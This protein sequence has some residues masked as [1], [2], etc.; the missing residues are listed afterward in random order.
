MGTDLKEVYWVHDHILSPLG[1]STQ[2][3]LDN[4]VQGHVGFNKY[5]APA[6]YNQET[7]ISFINCE[8]QNIRIHS[9]F[10]RLENLMIDSIQNLLNTNQIPLDE[11]TQLFISS[12]KGNID[13]I[14]NPLIQNQFEKTRYKLSQLGKTL[15]L[16]FGFAK[17]P[18]I[19]S[20][21]CVSGSLALSVA[22]DY[23]K[24][25]PIENA[26]IC[27]GDEISEF[28]YA[29]FNSFQ[30]LSSQ[31]CKPFDQ[32]RTGLNLGEAIVS[33]HLSNN[34]KS[35][36]PIGKMKGFG[37]VNDANHISGPSR[38][39]EGLFKSI[40]KAL[41]NSG[42]DKNQL[43]CISSHGTSTLYNDEM[44]SIALKRAGLSEVPL[45]SLKGYY[46]H[47]LGASALLETVLT[48]HSL[49]KNIILG[50]KGF[51]TEGTSS[52]VNI[53]QHH[54]ETQANY[55]LKLSSGFGGCNVAQITEIY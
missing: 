28:I 48:L 6:W 40:E 5:S 3:N 30:A 36:E 51:E 22:S 26:L 25:T 1:K 18:L 7:P 42:I 35:Y 10:T 13:L 52:S 34:S 50:T 43:G 55:F 38:T 32:N 14:H 23:L 47:T 46:G 27:G 21:A 20:N 19:I 12:T 31:T 2:E 8:E 29:G 54:R 45:H 9:D 17:T 53:S 15:Q 37:N 49:K 24:H 4:I 44:E 33:V 39:G 16:H 11:R 41:Q